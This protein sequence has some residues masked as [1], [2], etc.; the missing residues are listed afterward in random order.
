MKYNIYDS[1]SIPGKIINVFPEHILKKLKSAVRVITAECDNIFN[2]CLTAHKNTMNPDALYLDF[3]VQSSNSPNRYHHLFQKLKNKEPHTNFILSKDKISENELSF[4]VQHQ[5]VE[6]RRTYWEQYKIEECIEGAVTIQ[7]YPDKG[8]F[9]LDDKDI[10]KMRTVYE[11][12]HRMH[13]PKNVSIKSWRN[14]VEQYIDKENSII[15]RGAVGC[16][17]AYVL[18][19]HGDNVDEREIGWCY[20]EDSVAELMLRNAYQEK[21][22]YMKSQDVDYLW[23]EVD[24]SDSFACRLFEHQIRHQK[25]DKYTFIRKVRDGAKLNEIEQ[26]DYLTVHEWSKDE[27]FCERT[28]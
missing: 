22:K 3:N 13:P 28:G 6:L 26:S 24:T 4:L 17:R 18:I 14:I 19:Y 10:S 16:V 8:Y 23:I 1:E 21:L 5:F 15:I 12:T 20:F 25:A 2:G 9:R 11:Y 7:Y 27:I